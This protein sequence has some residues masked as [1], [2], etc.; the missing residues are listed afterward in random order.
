MLVSIIGW[1]QL[2][3]MAIKSTL[4]QLSQNARF[5]GNEKPFR[6]GDCLQA[7]LLAE[8]QQSRNLPQIKQHLQTIKQKISQSKS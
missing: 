2:H 4:Y 7:L 1:I 6:Q 3:S 8:K 5:G